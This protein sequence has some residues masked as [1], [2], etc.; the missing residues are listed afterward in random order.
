MEQKIQM[1]TTT[2]WFSLRQFLMFPVLTSFLVP[3][4]SLIL[5]YH[6]PW[7]TLWCLS[8]IHSTTKVHL[9]HYPF[10]YSSACS[11][12]SSHRVV[13]CFDVIFEFICALQWIFVL[14][15]LLIFIATKPK[16]VVVGGNTWPTFF[17]PSLLG[18]A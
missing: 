15:L 5:F 13:H 17:F 3:S 6:H 2:S 8:F 18:V 16:W 11:S 4:G 9:T 14:N 7:N 12:L 10:D 1:V